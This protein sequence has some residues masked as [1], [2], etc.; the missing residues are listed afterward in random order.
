MMRTTMAGLALVLA[1]APAM[2]GP[3][4][5]GGVTADEVASVMRALKLPVEKTT[6]R[7]GDPLILS[8]LGGRKFGVYFYQC[9]SERCASIQCSAG[10]EGAASVPMV[11]IHDWNR[12]KRFGRA[13][14][15]GG[16]LY[17]EMDMDVERGATT[18]ALANNFERWA[19]VMEQFPKFFK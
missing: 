17:V 8:T 15:D 13:Y 9:Q 5:D 3:L 19:A 18:E 14:A 6:D 11:K 7:Q 1:S 16:T 2:A 12:T 10:Y 4:P